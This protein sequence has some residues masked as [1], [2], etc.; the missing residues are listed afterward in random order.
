[1]DKVSPYG[2]SSL[3]LGSIR[4]LCKDDGAGSSSWS[5]SQHVLDDAPAFFAL[6]Y[7]WG[8]EKPT[9]R[10]SLEQSVV[11]I[12]LG[13]S[14]L[15]HQLKT[16]RDVRFIWIDQICINQQDDLEKAVQVKMMR[17]VYIS[18]HKVLLWLGPLIKG[19]DL[20]MDSIVPLDE[21]IGM[22]L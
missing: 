4:L 14:I 1:M 10:F 17:D 21:L 12:T 6:F 9:K 18:T 11:K 20:A 15:L 5:L 7:V 2:Y 8:T 16:R 13:L 19:S 22:L 3:L